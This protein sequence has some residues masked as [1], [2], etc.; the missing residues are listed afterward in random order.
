MYIIGHV[1]KIPWVSLI[2]SGKDTLA[3]GSEI[4]LLNYRILE[5]KGTLNF[6]FSTISHANS[7]K[8]KYYWVRIHLYGTQEF[9]FLNFPLLIPKQNK[10]ENYLFTMFNILMKDK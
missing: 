2:V 1:Q 3:I 8:I 6:T 4:K 7:I 9:A 5:Q 10:L